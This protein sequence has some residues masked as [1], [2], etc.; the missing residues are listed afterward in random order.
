MLRCFRKISCGHEGK[1]CLFQKDM[2]NSL[3][4]TCYQ[5]IAVRQRTADYPFVHY[6]SLFLCT[7]SVFY[8]GNLYFSMSHFFMLHFLHVLLFSYC[9]ISMFHFFLQESF[10]VALF[11]C[12]AIFHV[13]ILH[14]SIF[15]FCILFL[16]HSSHVAFCSCCTISRGLVRTPTNI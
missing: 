5:C 1:M 13:G 8:C 2:D 12:I 10:E 7:F 15:P 14:V 9:A 4:K 6:S 11:L 16:L 3:G